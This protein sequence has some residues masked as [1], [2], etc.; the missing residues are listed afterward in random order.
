MRRLLHRLVSLA[1]CLQIGSCTTVSVSTGSGGF[2]T[3]TP[4]TGTSVA[5]VPPYGIPFVPLG[6]NP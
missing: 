4:G 3:T 5:A 1:I 6:G 2:N